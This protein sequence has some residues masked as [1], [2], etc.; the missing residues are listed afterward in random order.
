MT[1]QQ[2]ELRSAR[3]AAI[4]TPKTNGVDAGSQLDLRELLRALQAVRDGDFSARLRSVSASS[5]KPGS[6][7]D[8]SPSVKARRIA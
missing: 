3:R 7:L 1:T 6:L 2:A 5:C 8:L 4:S